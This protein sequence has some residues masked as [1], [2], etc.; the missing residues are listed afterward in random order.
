ML[1]Y[2]WSDEL[3]GVLESSLQYIASGLL[4][5]FD[6]EISEKMAQSLK[7]K[8]VK[9]PVKSSMRLGHS[10]HQMEKK[11]PALVCQKSRKICLLQLQQ[12]GR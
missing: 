7:K 6:L 11:R 1:S 9:V 4:N 3:F 12:H 10:N 5:K 2:E 8:N